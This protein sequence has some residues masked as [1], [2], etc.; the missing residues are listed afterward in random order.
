M[1][2][3]RPQHV[4]A[5]I[6]STQDPVFFNVRN[7]YGFR[8]KI[9]S[10]FQ[11]QKSCHMLDA[12]VNQTRG[13][14]GPHPSRRCQEGAAR[15]RMNRS[16]WRKSQGEQSFSP[17]CLASALDPTLRKILLTVPMCL[18]VRFCFIGI[19][20]TRRMV[21]TWRTEMNK[22]ARTLETEETLLVACATSR[23][24]RGARDAAS[25]I[26]SPCFGD[27]EDPKL[28]CAYRNSLPSD[29]QIFALPPPFHRD[30]QFWIV[31][32]C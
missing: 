31:R 14:S 26:C 23:R 22:R 25:Y 5:N 1:N 12:A 15:E 32:W 18:T 29:S 6:Y 20:V 27:L 4:L 17:F 3:G 13:S 10:A 2:H 11:N 16:F 24:I 7:Q 8:C 19:V 9:C 30:L 28:C 21:A